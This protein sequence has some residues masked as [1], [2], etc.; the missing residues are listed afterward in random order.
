M[1]I[2]CFIRNL[3]N[4][5][6]KGKLYLFLIVTL[7]G[8]KTRL[9]RGHVPKALSSLQETKKDTFFSILL[10]ISFEPKSSKMGI[11]DF[12]KMVMSTINQQKFKLLI[13]KIL[14]VFPGDLKRTC[15]ALNWHDVKIDRMCTQC[16]LYSSS[17]LFFL[18]V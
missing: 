17:V 5:V 16:T 14:K 3:F 9:L 13:T 18:S 2:I 12:K 6:S 1:Y 10:C 7:E 4:F 8:V 15:F 11:L